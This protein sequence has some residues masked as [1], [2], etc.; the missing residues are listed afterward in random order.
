MDPMSASDTNLPCISPRMPRRDRMTA[1]VVAFYVLSVLCAPWIVRYA[2]GMETRVVEALAD[3]PRVM[4][5]AAAPEFGVPCGTS[6]PDADSRRTADNTGAPSN[7]DTLDTTRI[8]ARHI[9]GHPVGTEEVARDL[10]HDV[11]GRSAG[12]IVEARQALQARRA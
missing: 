6:M 12:I 5:C 11:I 4:R 9:V 3:G 7:Q 8:G 10:H 2:P 1:L